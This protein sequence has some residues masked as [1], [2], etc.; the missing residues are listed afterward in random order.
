MAQLNRRKLFALGGAG[1]AVAGGTGARGA[2][3]SPV[4][5]GITVQIA[6]RPEGWVVAVP[7]W[8]SVPDYASVHQGFMM[9]NKWIL[10]TDF[11]ELIESED[12]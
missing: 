4:L 6:K 1:I 8:D 11:L 2:E 12:F 3:I 9:P 10:L 7:D 5:P